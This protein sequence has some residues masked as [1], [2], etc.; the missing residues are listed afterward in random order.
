MQTFSRACKFLETLRHQ[1]VEV[2][3]MER[4]QM[5]LA[6]ASKSPRHPGRAQGRAKAAGTA[7]A[8]G[9]MGQCPTC[10]GS[11]GMDLP[12]RTVPCS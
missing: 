3:T 8:G 1:Y 10:K 5:L 2:S 9:L 12:G 11:E 4:R 6:M 7:R